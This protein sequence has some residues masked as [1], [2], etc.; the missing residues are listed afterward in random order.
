MQHR[1]VRCTLTDVSE[2]STASI[3]RLEEQAM[4][5]TNKKHLA[6]ISEDSDS[7]IKTNMVYTEHVVTP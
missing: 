6:N 7:L 3:I 5:E 1:V 2:E 4:Q